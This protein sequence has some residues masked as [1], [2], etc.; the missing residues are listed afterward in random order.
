MTPEIRHSHRLRFVENEQC[1]S[2]LSFRKETADRILNCDDPVRTTSLPVLDCA[3][4]RGSRKLPLGAALPGTTSPSIQKALEMT[5]ADSLPGVKGMECKLR[6]APIPYE[7]HMHQLH[8]R[9][10]RMFAVLMYVQ[11]AFAVIVALWLTPFFEWNG[12]ER[13]IHPHV[14]MAAVLG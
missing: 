1:L 2:I 14:W 11:W 4:M 13:R 3:D 8:A 6:S 12:S 9:I 10:D 5:N 7:E